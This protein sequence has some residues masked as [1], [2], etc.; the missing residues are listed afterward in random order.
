MIKLKKK[1]NHP[2]FMCRQYFYQGEVS[3][4]GPRTRAARR[5]GK[6]LSMRSNASQTGRETSTNTLVAF[7]EKKKKSKR[8]EG[9]KRKP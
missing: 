3:A 8:E 4:L 5:R 7:R 6:R 2:L 9:G 1:E